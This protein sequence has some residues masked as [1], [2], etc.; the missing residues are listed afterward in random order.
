M[1]KEG[2]FRV[3]AVL[4]HFFREGQSNVYGSGRA[5]ERLERSLAL[6]RCLNGLWGLRHHPQDLE[7]NLVDAKASLTSFPDL[8]GIPPWIEV[9]IHVLVNG[10]DYLDDALQYFGPSITIHRHYLDDPRQLALAARDF[11]VEHESPADL[12]LYL[13]DDLVIHDPFFPEKM[14]WMAEASQH[15][16]VLLPH[17]YEC[18][19]TPGAPPRLYVDGTIE[20]EDLKGWH[21]PEAGVANG[22]FRGWQAVSFDSP[23]NPHAGCFGLSRLQVMRLRD[24][25]MPCEGFIGPLETAA[26][27][28]VGK[29]FQLLKPCSSQREFLTIEHGH[30][31][32]L[33]YLR[34]ANSRSA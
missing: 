5:G 33:G 3:R 29:F 4:P 25:E 10:D 8:E 18:L 24:E 7:L 22:L 6:L 15:Q 23:V 11:L 26:T 28:T 19:R 13:E 27:Y 12:N 16:C 30:P 31:S 1:T 32:F 20:F 34:Q 14:L 2:L 21:Q 9:D 17:R